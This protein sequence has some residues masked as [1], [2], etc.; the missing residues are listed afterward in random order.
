M[1]GLTEFVPPRA[2]L[3]CVQFMAH[4]QETVSAITDTVKDAL[5]DPSLPFYLFTA[6]P[7]TVRSDFPCRWQ[8]AHAPAPL[9]DVFVTVS[10]V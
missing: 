9:L 1:V 6:P 2:P 8:Y 7:K 4:P 10:L 5:E 3:R